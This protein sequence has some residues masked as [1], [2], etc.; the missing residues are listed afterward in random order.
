MPTRNAFLKHVVAGTIAPYQLTAAKLVR[1][2]DRYAGKEGSDS[3]LKHLD[4]P[5]TERADVVRGTRTYVN[6]S[7]VN[8]RRFAELYAQLPPGQRVLGQ[9]F[10]EE[11]T[12]ARTSRQAHLPR[13]ND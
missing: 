2:M 3:R 8:G 10:V 13:M 5:E 4:F 12:A 6:G 11:L 9:D 7:R 1:L